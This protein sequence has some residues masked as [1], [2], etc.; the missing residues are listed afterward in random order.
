ML[1][2][3]FKMRNYLLHI[4]LLIGFVGFSQNQPNVYA[5]ADTTNIRIGETINYEIVVDNAD[6]G[7]NFSE[8]KLDSFAHI[9]VVE[10]FDI[11]TLKK[12][13]IKKYALTSFDS[14]RYVI[15]RQRVFIWSQEY[16]TDSLIIDVNTVAVDTT[17][18]QLFTIKSIQNEPY[19]FNDFK[20]YLWW[21]LLGLLLLAF[22]L[23]LIFR[24]KETPEEMEARI[25]PYQLALKRLNELDEKQ[26][27]QK[28]KI[29]EYYVELTGIL[30]SYIEREMKIPALES[31]SDELLETI[32]DFNSSSSLNIPKETIEKLQELLKESDL[33]K[34]AKYK[35]LANEIELHRNDTNTIIEAINENIPKVIVEKPKCVITKE[36]AIDSIT[37][38]KWFVP[39]IGFKMKKRKVLVSEKGKTLQQK[40][41]SYFWS[42]FNPVGNAFMQ[43]PILGSYLILIWFMICI[44][45][46]LPFVLVELISG[47]KPLNR[48]LVILKRNGEI[49]IKNDVADAIVG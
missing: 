19:T 30:R 39:F 32:T 38:Y 9:E 45:I 15:P 47:K 42:I 13:L 20:N 35:P 3:E 44:P 17:K 36:D 29:K 49:L 24:K 1:E 12:R 11:D 25:P 10:S 34:F 22:I 5:K 2:L 31:T 21:V 8:I 18:Q 27:W 4:T 41:Q 40:E 28:N 14:G 16:I 43:I 23:Y 37:L 7:V 6:T 46:A 33:V 26:L 48:G